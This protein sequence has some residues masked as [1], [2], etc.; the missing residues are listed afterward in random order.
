METKIEYRV[1][2]VTRYIVTR[3]HEND[4]GGAGVDTRGE[5]ANEQSA[6]DVGYAL[7]RAEHD[8]LGWPLGDMRIL[9]P[10]PP[11]QPMASATPVVPAAI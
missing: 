3:Y 2:S 1:R 4:D 10:A 5:Y 6:Y 7:C 8:W 11:G 9:Y